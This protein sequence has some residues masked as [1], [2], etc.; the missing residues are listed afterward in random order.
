MLSHRSGLF[1]R[2]WDVWIRLSGS[3]QLLQQHHETSAGSQKIRSLEKPQPLRCWLEGRGLSW[4]QRSHI[5]GFWVWG[6]PLLGRWQRSKCG[7]LRTWQCRGERGNALD[8]SEFRGHSQHFW[9]KKAE[10]D[11][12][13]LEC[14]SPCPHT[15]SPSHPSLPAGPDA[16]RVL[17]Q[18]P[19]DRSALTPFAGANICPLDRAPIRLLGDE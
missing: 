16:V 8:F 10:G 6:H 11:V 18:L 12:W 15:G 19:G 3:A 2:R 9:T 7:M 1:P 17:G 13:L 5:L 14:C 4:E